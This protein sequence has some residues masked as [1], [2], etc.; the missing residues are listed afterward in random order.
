MKT[1]HIHIENCCRRIS[2]AA[3]ST[4][5]LFLAT[6]MLLAFSLATARC[7]E[8]SAQ[9]PAPAASP[10]LGR[11]CLAYGGSLPEFDL[12]IPDTKAEAAEER[13]VKLGFSWARDLKQN[14]VC[15]EID[16][17]GVY[18][19]MGLTPV[20]ALAGAAY[21]S[22]AGES[23]KKL[24]PA[25]TTLTNAMAELQVQEALRR[26]LLR[27]IQEKSPQPV[28]L[29]TNSFPAETAFRVPSLMDQ[30]AP[31]PFSFAAQQKE[32]ECGP[33]AFEGM[34][35]LLLVRAIN[36]GLSGLDGHNS[37]LSFN[38]A[39]RV[40]LVR[41]ADR[42]QLLGFYAQYDSPPRKFVDWAVNNAQPFR[43]EF[44]RALQS[45]AGQIVAQSG[46]QLPQPQAPNGI[47]QA[48]TR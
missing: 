15:N 6:V 20:G 11:I 39:V 19:R 5:G 3:C 44:E 41:A 34:D 40:T 26:Q 25:I 23:A 45:L 17:L 38:M 33:S 47:V 27:L 36:H 43:A 42:T 28:R 18:I 46:L 16:A 13:A 14:R 1:N 21:G 32:K 30:Y 10:S 9:P 37:Q 22:V 48:S 29:V 31:L 7:A 35:T 8:D 2:P 12:Q 24:N 4:I